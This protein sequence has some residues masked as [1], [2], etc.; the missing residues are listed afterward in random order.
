MEETCTVK[1]KSRRFAIDVI[2]LYKDLSENR[3][4]YVLSK[5]VL[6]SGTSVGANIVEAEMA[7]SKREF[8]SKM[9][10]A[11]KECCETEYWLELLYETRYVEDTPFVALMSKCKEL[12]RM[13]SSIT[14]SSKES[15][16]K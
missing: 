10:I 4:E 16:E 13:L 12:E 7:I 5:Q 9:Y 6:R 2:N 8:L 3:K 14:K 1:Y 15:L 11:F